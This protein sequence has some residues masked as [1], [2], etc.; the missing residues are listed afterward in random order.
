MSSD[1]E[2]KIQAMENKLEKMEEN[3]HF[4]KELLT[5]LNNNIKDLKQ[6]K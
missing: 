6:K 3:I 2:T 1:N 4:L 5:H